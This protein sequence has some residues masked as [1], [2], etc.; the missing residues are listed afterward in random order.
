MVG[1]DRLMIV[2]DDIG[3]IECRNVLT[4]QLKIQLNDVP[5]HAVLCDS[6]FELSRSGRLRQIRQY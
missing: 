4:F 1:P 3:S 5:T 2:G 6:Y